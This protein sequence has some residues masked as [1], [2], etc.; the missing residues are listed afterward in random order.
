MLKNKLFLAAALSAALIT[1][2][3]A[4]TSTDDA[5]A[6]LEIEDAGQKQSYF[7]IVGGGGLG[8]IKDGNLDKI[9]STGAFKTNDGKGGV[10]RVGAGYMFMPYVGVEADYF[11]YLDTK[12][13]ATDPDP[14]VGK[15]DFTASSEAATL[16]AVLRY[17]I[18]NFAIFAKVGPS[19]N[20]DKVKTKVLLTKAKTTATDEHWEV[21]Y[22]GGFEYDL[23][24]T[25]ALQ[26]EYLVTSP[27]TS[28]VTI[29]VAGKF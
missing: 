13:S 27:D 10:W 9:T 20:R 14:A 4:D 6:M 29:N 3:F 16:L 7:Y 5:D 15:T 17:P 12:S 19:Y 18:N 28:A 8:V 23:I 21:A 11:G 2:A 25:F 24:H 1:P 22:G 26:L